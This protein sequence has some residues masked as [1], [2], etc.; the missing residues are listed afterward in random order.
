MFSAVSWCACGRTQ[1]GP[2]DGKRSEVGSLAP[3]FTLKDL[4]G[5]DVRLSGYR[6]RVVLLDFWATWCPPCKATVPELV[7]LEHKYGGKGLVVLAVSLDDGSN[8][9]AKL[10]AFSREHAINYTVLLGNE[11]VEKKYNI[12]SIPAM[13][14]IG[15]DGRILNL[16]MGYM[17]NLQGIV[18]SEIDRLI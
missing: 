3:D 5:R 9:A 7:A 6:G 15:R 8:T 11:D 10:S 2:A 14:V 18:S 4:Q 1:S 17:E 13:Y 12:D 16:H